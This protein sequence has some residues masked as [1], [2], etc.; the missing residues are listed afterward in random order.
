VDRHGKKTKWRTF[1]KSEKGESRET[2][3]KAGEPDLQPGQG[4][5]KGGENG[6]LYSIQM[7][8]QRGRVGGD[9]TKPAASS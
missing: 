4:T 6:S 5:E 7:A 9:E 3:E 8:Q 2:G 1:E